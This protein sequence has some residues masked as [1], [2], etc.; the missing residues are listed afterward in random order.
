MINECERSGEKSVAM[1]ED[2]D[3][4][5]KN[6]DSTIEL[7]SVSDAHFILSSTFTSSRHLNYILFMKILMNNEK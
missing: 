4:G 1:T 6:T 7:L 3:G 5:I 2:D